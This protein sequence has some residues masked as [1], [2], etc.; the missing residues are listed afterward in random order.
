MDAASEAGGKA[1]DAVERSTD[2]PWFER[3]ARAGYVANGILHGMLG[4]LA[5]QLALGEKASAD[6]TGAL[7]KISQQPFGAVLLWAGFAACLLLGLW[8]LVSAVFDK[9][10]LRT[11][12]RN[13]PT[14]KSGLKRWKPIL[15]NLGLGVTFLAVSGLFVLFAA[16]SSPDSSENTSRFSAQLMST[17]GGTFLLL[18]LGAV[19]LAAG[20][21][22]AYRGI[23][24]K[25][26]DELAL[27]SGRT[28]RRA[29]R[30]LGMVGY[31]AKGVALGL[32]G[33]LFIV[34]TLQH[35][36]EESTGLDGALKS[37]GDHPY[38]PPLLAVIGV[39]LLCY[40]GYLVLRSRYDR[41]D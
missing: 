6:Q 19:I 21:F 7:E 39:G 26:E 11:L 15:K 28:A 4:V 27:P 37:L 5:F 3:G 30:I 34:A 20:L 16:G 18:L 12:K 41:M 24:H 31:I 33:L 40:G 25:F 17:P 8:H 29:V 35:D 13:K 36:P 1:A 23:L 9:G 38:G 2:N 14:T 10:G 22:F 32:L